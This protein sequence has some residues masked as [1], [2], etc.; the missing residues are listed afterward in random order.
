MS[1]KSGL[2]MLLARYF[3]AYAAH[4][5]EGCAE[6][7]TH[8]AGLYSPFGPPAAGR[9]EIAATHAEWFG[10]AEFDKR[11]EIVESG[12]DGGS[13]YCLLHYSAKIPRPDGGIDTALGM[14]LSVLRGDS[15][16]GWEF[17]LMSLNEIET[18]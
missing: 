15:D 6:C 1:F 14:S 16:G 8:D 4:D 5:A 18:G 10:E 17:H 12:S 9:V 13:G 3:T 11:Y 2:E 7:Y